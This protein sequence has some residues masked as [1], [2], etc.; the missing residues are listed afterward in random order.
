M[1]YIS[2]YRDEEKWQKQNCF[3]AE[4][5]IVPIARNGKDADL[6]GWKSFQSGFCSEA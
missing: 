2:L 5:F 3:Q 6:I 1:G 4:G